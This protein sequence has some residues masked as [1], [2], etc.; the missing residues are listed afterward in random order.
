VNGK[1]RDEA[2]EEFKEEGRTVKLSQRP[3]NIDV[4]VENHYNGDIADHV[5]QMPD[6]RAWLRLSEVKQYCGEDRGVTNL[7]LIPD[8]ESWMGQL[9][10]VRLPDMQSWM[11]DQINYSYLDDSPDDA[12]W[13]DRMDGSRVRPTR[14]PM[15]SGFMLSLS[16]I[17]E[18]SRE[19]YAST[20]SQVADTRSGRSTPAASFLNQSK[21]SYNNSKVDLSESRVSSLV[22]L[23][24]SYHYPVGALEE[25]Q[26]AFPRTLDLHVI[27]DERHQLMKD[28]SDVITYKNCEV[29][30]NKA[31]ADLYSCSSNT[32]EISDLNSVRPSTLENL[33]PTISN[34]SNID[35]S[36]ESQKVISESY[37]SEVSSNHRILALQSRLGENKENMPTK[38][39]DKRIGRGTSVQRNSP[40]AFQSRNPLANK[41]CILNYGDVLS[42]A[43]TS[44]A[45]S[46]TAEEIYRN[47]ITMTSGQR[48]PTQNSSTVISDARPLV[49]NELR[50]DNL[51]IVSKASD[52]VTPGVISSKQNFVNHSSNSKIKNFKCQS[53]TI[54]KQVETNAY[55]DIFSKEIPTSVRDW[56]DSRSYR[57]NLIEGVI[58][59]GADDAQYWRSPRQSTRCRR[60]TSSISDCSLES[61]D[62]TTY[63]EISKKASQISCNNPTESSRAITEKISQ[64][65]PCVTNEKASSVSCSTN[66]KASFISINDPHSQ[67]HL[68]IGDKTSNKSCDDNSFYIPFPDGT[69]SAYETMSSTPIRSSAIKKKRDLRRDKID[70]L[71]SKLSACSCS[72]LSIDSCV[73]LPDTLQSLAVAAARRKGVEVAVQTA[74]PISSSSSNGVL[75]MTDFAP[76]SASNSSIVPVADTRLLRKETSGS[77]VY[78]PEH[79][80][81]PES[82]RSIRARDAPVSSMTTVSSSNEQPCINIKRQVAAVGSATS[83]QTPQPSSSTVTSSVFDR[84]FISGSTQTTLSSA[85][86]TGSSNV[87]FLMSGSASTSMLSGGRLDT[88]ALRTSGSSPSTQKS[89]DVG[90]L[91]SDHAHLDKRRTRSLSTINGGWSYPIIKIRQFN[92]QS[93]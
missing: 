72:F 21:R 34:T 91:N 65:K 29:N 61:I 22:D 62:K 35:N 47:P 32:K 16:D 38:L 12:A 46:I 71:D 51:K 28:N 77:S 43:T 56:G 78:C 73:P 8:V 69:N 58:R 92:F 57:N 42:S 13:E 89:K 81:T 68:T 59:S 40:N 90:S 37:D 26:R 36:P 4:E 60:L 87:G 3:S 53:D 41:N 52:D 6:V 80:L 49:I 33:A 18:R 23:D 75:L 39:R 48:V 54:L 44:M 85:F 24:T 19:S 63:N 67:A 64:S 1:K 11:H 9:P 31:R 20:V 45:A 7:N 86:D 66:E 15:R 82:S 83:S 88:D 17:E 93:A 30:R 10:D 76:A 79:S 27:A 14:R 55:G 70:E 5:F 25:Q 84:G 74:R 50:K 2:H